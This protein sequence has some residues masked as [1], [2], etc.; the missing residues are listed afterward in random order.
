M[1]PPVIAVLAAPG[2]AAKVTGLEQDVAAEAAALPEK[3][4]SV[5]IRP[6]VTLMTEPISA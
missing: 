1:S 2:L 5:A 4:L 3:P 6:F